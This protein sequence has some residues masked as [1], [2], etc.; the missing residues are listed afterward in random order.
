MTEDFTG[1][2]DEDFEALHKDFLVKRDDN[3]YEDKIEQLMIQ[4]EKLWSKPDLH[5]MLIEHCYQKKNYSAID[6]D[7]N[8]TI[9]SDCQ[10]EGYYKGCHMIVFVHGF[11]GSS[12][13][14]KILKNYFSMIH[15]EAVFLLSEAN[16][17]NTENC[18]EEMGEKLAD[19]VSKKIESYCPGTS[20]GRLSFIGHSMGGIIIRSALPH[21]EKY[22]EKMFT[23]ISLST[24]HLGYM[25]NSSKIISTGMW[26][27]KQWKKSKSLSQLTMTDS[28]NREDSF[29]YKLSCAEGLNW[30]KNIILVSSF[31]DSYAPFDSAR[32]QNCNQA[33]KDMKNGEFYI[34]M[35]DNILS[36]LITNCIYRIDVNF[37]IS[38][39]TIDTFIGRAAHIHF[40]ENEHFMRILSHRFVEFFD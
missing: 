37:M 22:K 10:Y 13:D 28:S 15:P 38:E 5:P 1:H 14:M 35:A 40:L 24:P 12:T 19:E 34:K 29:L 17:N 6:I 3:G 25:Y 23:Y 39:K 27:L 21:L 18:I 16:H 7:D 26:F 9:D 32:I 8:S 20:L 4:D 11:Q 30:F 31:K 2:T 33:T 36:R